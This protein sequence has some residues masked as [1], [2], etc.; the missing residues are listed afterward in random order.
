MKRQVHLH[1]PLAV[2]SRDPWGTHSCSQS[3]QYCSSI[4]HGLPAPHS[5]VACSGLPALPRTTQKISNWY[6][7][8]VPSWPTHRDWHR[9]MATETKFMASHFIEGTWIL[10]HWVNPR[11]R[12]YS[13][14]KWK[15]APLFPIFSTS[16][17]LSFYFCFHEFKNAKHFNNHGIGQMYIKVLYTVFSTYTTIKHYFKT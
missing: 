7:T 4:F 12:S 11:P 3:S 1:N 16:W 10:C 13:S 6:R 9:Q 14:F 2:L 17:Q 8:R 5:W 15:F